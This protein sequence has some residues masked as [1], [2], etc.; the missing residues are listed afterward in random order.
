VAL[1]ALVCGG[2]GVLMW[3]ALRR[4]AAASDKTT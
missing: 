3:W 4:H 1:G 2:A